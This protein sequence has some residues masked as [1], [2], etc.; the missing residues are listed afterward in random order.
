MLRE[1]VFPSAREQ[2]AQARQMWKMS[3]EQDVARLSIEPLADT[4]GWVARLQIASRRKFRERV[5]RGPE[6]M[7][8]LFRPQ[9]PAVPHDGRPR[10]P[11]RRFGR[12]ALNSCAPGRR[13]RTLRIDRLV[14]RFAV[15]NQEEVHETSFTAHVRHEN[16]ENAKL[17]KKI[18]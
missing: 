5:A 1:V 16:H 12:K 11:R 6:G 15:M 9:L 13:Q 18:F 14:D 8:R 7:S 4:K 10:A 3:G 2:R 17:T